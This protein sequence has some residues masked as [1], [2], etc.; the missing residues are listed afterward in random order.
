MYA[1][2]CGHDSTVICL[3]ALCF[4]GLS[5]R[6]VCAYLSGKSERA[7]DWPHATRINGTTE[8]VMPGS[9]GRSVW[10]TSPIQCLHLTSLLLYVFLTYD[11]AV[12][13]LESRA[14]ACD[15][16]AGAGAAERGVAGGAVEGWAWAVGAGRRRAAGQ[17]RTGADALAGC[18]GL[19]GRGGKE[20]GFR[21]QQECAWLIR[22]ADELHGVLI[23]NCWLAN[24][25]ISAAWAVLKEKM[26]KRKENSDPIWK[27]ARKV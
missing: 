20:K 12:F 27:N 9:E 3:R 23:F 11:P 25:C 10:I 2:S 18:G 26:K 14:G 15:G 6:H 17:G 13:A 22:Y 1:D 8:H 7:H 24:V 4:A 16:P 21:A 19:P 5:F